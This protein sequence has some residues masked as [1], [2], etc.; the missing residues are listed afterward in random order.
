MAH[1]PRTRHYVPRI[2]LALG[3]PVLRY[4]K[5]RD[6]YVLRLVGN[7]RGPV[8]RR[9]RRHARREHL[10]AERRRQLSAG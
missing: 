5:T 9:D 2:A 8:L 4:S 3:W 7:S 1:E 6:A 10:G